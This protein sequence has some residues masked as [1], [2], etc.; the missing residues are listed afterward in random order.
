MRLYR[1]TCL[2]YRVYPGQIIAPLLSN[3]VQAPPRSRPQLRPGEV[4][5]NAGGGNE[6]TGKDAPYAEDVAETKG[7]DGFALHFLTLKLL[8]EPKIFT[9]SRIVVVGASDAGLSAL[10]SLMLTPYMRTLI[11]PTL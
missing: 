6:I 3:L 8:S 5:G 10:E 11:Y 1:K 2:Y 9:H 7:E 4:R